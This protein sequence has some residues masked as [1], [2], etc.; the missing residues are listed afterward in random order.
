MAPRPKWQSGMTAYVLENEGQAGQIA[1]LVPGPFLYLVF[2]E[3]AKGVLP[4]L[5]GRHIYH[6][7]ASNVGTLL[8]AVRPTWDNSY[9]LAL[10]RFQTVGRL[11]TLH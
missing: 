6:L 9:L 5:S 11:T 3:P 7:L 10:G 1:D 2:G 8:A 4:N